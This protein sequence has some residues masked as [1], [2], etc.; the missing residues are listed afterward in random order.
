MMLIQKLPGFPRISLVWLPL[1]M[2]TYEFSK[3]DKNDS[4]DEEKLL[5]IGF[6]SLVQP[7]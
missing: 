4:A 6:S 3:Y 1:R 5:E 2:F 7:E